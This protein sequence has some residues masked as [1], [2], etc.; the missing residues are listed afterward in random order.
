MPRRRRWVKKGAVSKGWKKTG[1]KRRANRAHHSKVVQKQKSQTLVYH[2]KYFGDILPENFITTHPFRTRVVFTTGGIGSGGP[3][4]FAMKGSS[5]E[6]PIR[7]AGNGAYGN[8]YVYNAATASIGSVG[9]IATTFADTN[10]CGG[11]NTLNAIYNKCQVISSDLSITVG[12]SGATD[13]VKVYSYPYIAVSQGVNVTPLFTEA[14]LDSVRAVKS[15][16]A[17]VNNPMA[18]MHNH[19]QSFDI[20]GYQNLQT[21]LA[22]KAGNAFSY[23]AGGINTLPQNAWKWLILYTMSDA[24]ANAGTVTLDITVKY[25]CKWSEL[26]GEP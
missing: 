18:R 6:T 16:I 1:R 8:L 10:Q 15:V 20:L 9:A 19:M 21:F 22:D 14:S 12:C 23:S 4:Y 17:N 13:T 5:I 26:L 3:Y 24:T 7:E 2:P 25:R 11:H